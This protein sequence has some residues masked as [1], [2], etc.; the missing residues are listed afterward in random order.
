[1]GVCVGEGVRVC[2][3]CGCAGV[4]VWVCVGVRVC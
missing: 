1:L 2:C 3:V 4:L